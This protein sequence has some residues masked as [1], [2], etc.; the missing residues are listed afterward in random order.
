MSIPTIGRI[1]H[2]VMPAG[3]SAGEHRPAIIVHVN[4]EKPSEK[5]TVSLQVFTE[6]A[7]DHRA[8]FWES[9]VSQDKDKNRG[10]WHEP[11]RNG[12]QDQEVADLALLKRLDA[13]AKKLHGTGVL[14]EEVA[15]VPMPEGEKQ[16]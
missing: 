16:S 6:P 8:I 2:F 4:D 12:G 9:N 3:P 10:T 15:P 5:S 14:E 13:L 1:V 7:R 11:E